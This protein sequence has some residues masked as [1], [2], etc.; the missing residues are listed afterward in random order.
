MRPVAAPLTH[1]YTYLYIYMYIYDS[2]NYG[3]VYICIY[4]KAEC[5]QTARNIEIFTLKKASILKAASCSP[6]SL[7]RMN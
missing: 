7:I 5:P 3:D 2:T 4:M 6:S 1:M